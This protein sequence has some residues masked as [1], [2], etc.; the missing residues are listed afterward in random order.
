[1]REVSGTGRVIHS[2]RTVGGGAGAPVHAAQQGP[3]HKFPE[4]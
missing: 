2:V 1:M 3:P 4:H